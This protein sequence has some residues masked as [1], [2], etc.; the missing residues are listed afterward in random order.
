MAQAGL[1]LWLAV[2]ASFFGLATRV[3]IPP[4]AWIALTLL[5]HVTRST[6]AVPG[7]PYLWLALYLSLAIAK[8]SAELHGGTLE[9]A[10]PEAGGT[11]VT[12]TLPLLPPSQTASAAG[13]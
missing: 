6:R 2:G 3:A 1:L 8:R 13:A 12:L 7:I 4:I 10:C 11:N 9:L 5:V